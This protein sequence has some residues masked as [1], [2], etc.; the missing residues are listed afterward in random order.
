MEI[1]CRL[2]VLSISRNTVSTRESKSSAGLPPNSSMPVWYKHKLSRN[3]CAV[4]PT[5]AL[6]SWVVRRCIESP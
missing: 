4:M 3:S 2:T 6:I 1:N 5:G